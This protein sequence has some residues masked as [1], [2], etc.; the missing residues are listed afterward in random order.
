MTGLTAL[1]ERVIL[2]TIRDR[3]LLLAVLVPAGTF[4]GFNLALRPLIDTGGMSYAQ[5]RTLPPWS[6]RPCCWVR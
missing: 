3:D 4:I 2:G 6:S 1:I 5:Y